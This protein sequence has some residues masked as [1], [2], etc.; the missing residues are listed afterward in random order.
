MKLAQLINRAVAPFG[1]MIVPKRTE[2][3]LYQHEYGSGGYN[4][5]KR[6]QIRH[7]KRKLDA[8]WADEETLECIARY[9]EDSPIN[10]SQGLCHGARNGWEVTWFKKRLGCQ[11]IGTDISDTANGLEDMVQHDFHDVKPDWI[12][13]FSFI[14]TNSLDQAFAPDRALSAWADQLSPG[15][16]IFIE[17]TMYHSASHASEMDP[18]GAHPM[19]MPYLLFE[20]GR[21]KYALADILKAGGQSNRRAVV[22][23]KGQVWVFVVKKI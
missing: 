7:N 20:W 9:L 4:E 12:G 19:V 11:M 1:L 14:Y 17:H 16:A 13:K 10:L 5:Y 23:D 21:G 3:L 2:P 18:F 6:I 8:V 22:E 15:G